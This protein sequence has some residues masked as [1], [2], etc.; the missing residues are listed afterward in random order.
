MRRNLILLLVAGALFALPL[1]AQRPRGAEIRIDKFPAI[2]RYGTQVAMAPNGDFI[3]VYD[4]VGGWIAARLWW[5]LD[6]LGHRG[7]AGL[8]RCH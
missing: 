5:M 4:D 2:N 6:D 7:G 8:L 3:V 1:T